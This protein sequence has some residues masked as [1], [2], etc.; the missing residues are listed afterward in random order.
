MEIILEEVSGDDEDD[1]DGE[2]GQVGSDHLRAVLNASPLL[3]EIQGLSGY[4]TIKWFKAG[5]HHLTK[6]VVASTV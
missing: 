1:A 4:E 3:T 6:K 2:D 5:A